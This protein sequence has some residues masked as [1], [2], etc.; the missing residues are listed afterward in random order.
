MQR[1]PAQH[2]HSGRYEIQP[3]EPRKWELRSG[4]KRRSLHT[5]A[6]AARSAADRLERFRRLR[7]SALRNG[8]VLIG[9]VAASSVLVGM[10]T[11]P[12]PDHA[13]AVSYTERIETA[14]RSVVAGESDLEGFLAESDGFAGATVEGPP[15]FRIEGGAVDEAPATP[16]PVSLL[17]GE[18]DGTCFTLRWEEP[19]WPATG[20]LRRGYP[21]EAVPTTALN[22]SHALGASSTIAGLVNWDP[23]L[24]PERVQVSCFF[25]AFLVV[26][27]VGM[28]SGVGLTLALLE[29]RVGRGAILTWPDAVGV[30]AP[31]RG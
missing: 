20:I 15:V 30:G 26:L 28:W 29:A 13:S 3:L 18:H 7:I 11:I 1:E 2:D 24:P 10:R 27:A 21:C 17:V 23:L 6:S 8:L 31:Q 25:P 16:A 12:N 5:T 4:G 19:D 9:V 14:Y 22:S